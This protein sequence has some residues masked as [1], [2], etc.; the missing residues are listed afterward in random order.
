[1]SLGCAWAMPMLT[2]VLALALY[3]AKS[4][5][6]NRVERAERAEQA[7]LPPQPEPA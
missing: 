4:L 1:M 3:R 2:V 6:R 7:G 5:G